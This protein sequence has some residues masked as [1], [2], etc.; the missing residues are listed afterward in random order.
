MILLSNLCVLAFLG[1]DV[2]A[3][4]A[5]AADHASPI[6]AVEPQGPPVQF[7]PDA[8]DTVGPSGGT[9]EP[10]SILLLVGSALGYGAWR[11]KRNKDTKE[12]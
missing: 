7:F 6:A 8:E 12:S 5:I 2:H 3:N 11:L 1:A 9:P 4:V 10:G